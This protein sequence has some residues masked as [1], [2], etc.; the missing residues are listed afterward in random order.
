ME[1]DGAAPRVHT[2]GYREITL[3]A[4]NFTFRLKAS[5]IKG[6]DFVIAT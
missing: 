2:P 5:Q 1:G 3:Y 6:A 4:N